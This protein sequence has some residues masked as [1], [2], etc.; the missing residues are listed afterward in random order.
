MIHIL[1]TRHGQ[2]D[3]NRQMKIQG[4]IEIPLNETGISQAEKAHEKLLN[5]PIDLIFSSPLGRAKKTAEIIRGSRD[6]PIIVDDDLEEE[7]YGDMEGE[8][9]LDNEAYLRQRTSYFKRYPHG[10]SYFDVYHRVA[11][12]FEKLKKEYDGKV[13][14][15]LIVA[16]GGMSRVVNLYFKDMENDDFATYGIDNCQIVEYDLK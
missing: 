7:F 3:W 14:T 13:N 11:R 6:I 15:V 8:S 2:T 12:F 5:T 16:H 4:H 9:R 1:F 10:E